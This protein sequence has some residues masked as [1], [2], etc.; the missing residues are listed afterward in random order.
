MA[1]LGLGTDVTLTNIATVGEI[2][3][4]RLSP[5][6]G[7]NELSQTTS[8]FVRVIP[9]GIDPGTVIISVYYDGGNSAEAED[10][11]DELKLL[12]SNVVTIDYPQGRFVC[13]GYVSGVAIGSSVNDAMTLD[14]SIRLDGEWEFS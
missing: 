4:V 7:F 1:I 9:T 3:E 5:Q 13:S 10:F 11:L 12:R 14:I 8:N 2:R 6:A